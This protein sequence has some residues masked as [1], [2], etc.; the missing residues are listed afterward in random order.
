MLRC[1]QSDKSRT[2]TTSNLATDGIDVRQFVLDV[3]KKGKPLG[4]TAGKYAKFLLSPQPIRFT[5]WDL[6]GQEVFYPSHQFFLTSQA[7]YLL[8]FNL[9]DVDFD[10]LDYWM[11]QI[12]TSAPRDQPSPVYLVGTH[13]DDSR[14]QE[15]GYLRGIKEQIRLRYPI[16]R[17]P[18][19]RGSMIVDCKSGGRVRTLKKVVSN[20]ATEMSFSVSPSWILLKKR[21]GVMLQDGVHYLSFSDYRD[22]AVRGHV[23]E[24]ELP[25]A[26]KFLQNVGVIIHFEGVSQLASNL[27]VLHPQWLA[28]LMASFVSFSSRWDRDGL[29]PRENIPQV[30]KGFNT[31]IHESLLDVLERFGILVRLPKREEY[32]RVLVPCLL[33]PDRP[34]TFYRAPG[35]SEEGS[36]CGI[37]PQE[38]I[39]HGRVYDFPFVPLGFFER[40]LA[41]TFFLSMEVTHNT[42]WRNGVV[43]DCVEKACRS[44]LTFST[45]TE[46][47]ATVYSLS[48]RTRIDIQCFLREGINPLLD[49]L[50]KMVENIITCFFPRLQDSVRRYIPCFH[51]IRR[52]TVASD[53]YYFSFEECVSAL[54]RNDP[55]VFCRGFRTAQ[56]AVHVSHLAPDITFSGYTLIDAE[57]LGPSCEWDPIGQGAFGTVYRGNYRNQA[58]AI[59]QLHN[60]TE[61]NLLEQF[62]EFQREVQIM[63]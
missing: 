4:G 56:R 40:I 6:G 13:A 18:S 12:R 45:R 58:V 1:L 51:C 49:E 25:L 37:C 46:G 38:M 20:M 28:D 55:V 59:K 32:T 5:A 52:Q 43:L 39:E 41:G 22:L 27:V 24:E 2:D 8:I 47:N 7:I 42:V 31:D 50:V 57:D 29:I 17:F 14:C 3:C 62:G 34:D 9:V 53:P 23:A 61:D 21:L 19:F 16:Q 15:E 48:I 30:L 10:R 35:Q 54:T 11:N 36:W 26:T 63:R 60:L 33:P 44:F